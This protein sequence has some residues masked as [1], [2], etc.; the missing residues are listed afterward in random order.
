M[1]RA[2]P[3]Y[4]SGRLRKSRAP[5]PREEAAGEEVSEHSSSLCITDMAGRSLTVSGEI[6]KVFSVSPVVSLVIYAC[7]GEACRVEL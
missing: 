7:S 6:N 3:A 1:F 2:D 4:A 5:A